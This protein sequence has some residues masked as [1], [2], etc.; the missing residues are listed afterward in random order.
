MES[1]LFDAEVRIKASEASLRAL[2]EKY[3]YE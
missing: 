2:V 3:V 1:L